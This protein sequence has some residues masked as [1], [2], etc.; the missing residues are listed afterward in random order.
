M[1]KWLVVLLFG[2]SLLSFADVKVTTSSV[3][4]WQGEELAVEVKVAEESGL[5]VNTEAPWSITFD[6]GLELV[7]G[8][9]T[10]DEKLP[11]YTVKFKMGKNEAPKKFGY[12]VTAFFCTK[13]KQQCFRK[14]AQGSVKVPPRS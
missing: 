12:R 11:G 6:E 8:K 3:G 4:T 13:D 2:S 14:M 10:L 7:G 1:K 5:V 9:P